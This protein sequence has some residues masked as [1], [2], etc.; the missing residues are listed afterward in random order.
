MSLSLGVSLPSP[1]TPTDLL[2]DNRDEFAFCRMSYKWK[3]TVCPFWLLSTQLI[4]FEIQHGASVSILSLL[5]AEAYSI[6]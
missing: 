4:Y 1:P 6:G 5:I 2:S 3:H